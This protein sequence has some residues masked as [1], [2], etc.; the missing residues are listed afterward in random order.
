MDYG[1]SF[2]VDDSV[3]T[4]SDDD[5]FPDSATYAYQP[6]ISTPDYDSNANGSIR[7]I[8]PSSDNTLFTGLAKVGLA[9]RNT[10]DSSG[11]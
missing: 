5:E 11:L 4:A 7:F 10:A 9:E 1:T 8:S 6:S 2:T 3:A